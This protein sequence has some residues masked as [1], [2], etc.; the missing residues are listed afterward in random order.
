MEQLFIVTIDGR[1]MYIKG[2][3]SEHE[4][5]LVDGIAARLQKS[6][7]K[8]LDPEG[9]LALLIREAKQTFHILL[10]PI[11]VKRVFRI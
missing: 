3:L 7:C 6:S 2:D 9:K 5:Y 11:S 1:A 10:E 4:E 8:K